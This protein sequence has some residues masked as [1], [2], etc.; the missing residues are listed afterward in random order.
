M[1]EANISSE[2]SLDQQVAQLNS[3]NLILKAELGTSKKK[4]EQLIGIHSKCRSQKEKI[5]VAIQ[6]ST[7]DEVTFIFVFTVLHKSLYIQE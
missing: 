3:D 4:F 6:T 7:D 5:S 2:S 1:Q